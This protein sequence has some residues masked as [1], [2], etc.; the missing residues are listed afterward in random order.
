MLELV[1]TIFTLGV[2]TG[3]LGQSSIKCMV[4]GGHIAHKLLQILQFGRL[5]G[6][7]GRVEGF[8]SIAFAMS[9]GWP[10]CFGHRWTVFHASNV[11]MCA[12]TWTGVVHLSLYES[13]ECWTSLPF[14][15][16]CL[17]FTIIDVSWVVYTKS[18]W[19]ILCTG[20]GFTFCAFSIKLHQ[21]SGVCVVY[22]LS[23]FEGDNRRTLYSGK[24]D[25]LDTLCILHIT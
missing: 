18:A 4:N 25:R 5:D 10:A 19:S 7:L 12:E 24:T 6:S 15:C 2:H 20:N 13:S 8:Y 22:H 23:P 11:S 16:W 14:A 1:I 3:G 9:E 17:L 21:S